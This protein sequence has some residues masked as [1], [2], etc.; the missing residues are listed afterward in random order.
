MPFIFLFKIFQSGSLFCDIDHI[1]NI[2]LS[3]ATVEVSSVEN[4]GAFMSPHLYEVKKKPLHIKVYTWNNVNML[5]V[6]LSQGLFG[7]K[8]V[9]I[10]DIKSDNTFL[11]T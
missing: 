3:C 11:N 10:R 6:N 7:I 1:R 8:F 5:K 9:N 2:I 4:K